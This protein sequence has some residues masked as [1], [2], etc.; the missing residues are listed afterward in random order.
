ML[1]F[2]TCILLA[3]PPEDLYRMNNLVAWCVVPF[4]A[5]NRLP[6]ERVAMLKK[7]GF[8]KLAYDWRDKHLPTLELELHHCI[9]Q[10]IQM[11]AIWFP[12]RIN[13][14]A[15]WILEV[16]QRNKTVAELWVNLPEP[17]AETN[18]DKIKAAIQQLQPLVDAASK[19]GCTVCLYHHGGWIGE[20]ETQLAILKAFDATKVGVIYNLHHGHHHLDKFAEVLK[21]LKPYLKCITLNGMVPEGDK[22][23]KKIMPVGAGSEDLKLLKMIRNSGYTGPI[24]I[25]GHEHTVDVEERLRDNLDGLN[26]LKTQ[27]DGSPAGPTPMWR[28]YK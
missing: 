25:L 19:I 18:E 22:K 6:P 26:W 15:K 10:G 1:T 5:K 16:L 14:E 8:T 3:V 28:S 9:D 27:L 21:Q 20:P 12:D 13:F 7:L 24:A 17:E 23:G 11:H 2:L 4:D